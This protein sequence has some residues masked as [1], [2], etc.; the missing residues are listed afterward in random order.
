MFLVVSIVHTVFHYHSLATLVFSYN[1]FLHNCSRPAPTPKT[2]PAKGLRGVAGNSPE[3]SGTWPTEK[4]VARGISVGPGADWARR[5]MICGDP[6]RHRR[7][8]CRQ[9]KRTGLT[10]SSIQIHWTKLSRV[11]R[12]WGDEKRM[13]VLCP[14]DGNDERDAVFTSF[15]IVLEKEEKRVKE[16]RL[17]NLACL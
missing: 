2:K 9:R 11:W 6:A 17:Y 14:F 1:S 8:W 7:P 15:N 5:C 10:G 16:S 12:A 4:R 3:G 13:V